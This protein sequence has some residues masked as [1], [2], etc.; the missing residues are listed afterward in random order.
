MTEV[1]TIKLNTQI[2]HPHLIVVRQTL[3]R[4]EYKIHKHNS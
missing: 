2:I 1:A 3:I 4:E